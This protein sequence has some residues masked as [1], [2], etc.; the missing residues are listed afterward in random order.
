MKKEKSKMDVFESLRG[1]QPAAPPD[2]LFN[3]ILNAIE[4]PEFTTTAPMIP[5]RQLRAVAASLLLLACLNGFAIVQ[6][7]KPGPKMNNQ[8][9]YSNLTN[10]YNL[11]E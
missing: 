9:E 6:K 7:Y 1:M 5:I 2:F 8:T 4:Q 10:N 11:Y 3:S